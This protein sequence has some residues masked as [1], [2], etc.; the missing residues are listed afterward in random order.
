[1]PSSPPMIDG[2]PMIAVL[3]VATSNKKPF[4]SGVRLDRAWDL[5]GEQMWETSEFRAQVKGPPYSKDSWVNCS[6]SPVCEAVA[7]DGRV[8]ASLLTLSC[9]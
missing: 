9:G 1:M 3:K 4:P 2:K 7:R 8:R 5:F 6:D